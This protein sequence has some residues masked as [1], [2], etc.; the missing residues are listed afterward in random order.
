M[1]RLIIKQVSIPV[2]FDWENATIDRCR[3]DMSSF[4]SSMVRLGGTL[5]IIRYLLN[6]RFNSSMVRLGEF[7]YSYFNPNARFQFQY[8]SIGRK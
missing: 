4:N 6:R 1:L 3:G 5:V 2:W 8:G 7:P